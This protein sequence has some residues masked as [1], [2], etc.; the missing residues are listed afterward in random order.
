MLLWAEEGDGHAT[1]SVSLHDHQ[2][3]LCLHAGLNSETRSGTHPW[4][5]SSLSWS[6]VCT[7]LTSIVCRSSTF[8]HNPTRTKPQQLTGT[9]ILSRL[10]YFCFVAGALSPNSLPNPAFAGFE[11]LFGWT[12][13]VLSGLCWGV[14]LACSFGDELDFFPAEGRSASV[15]D[16]LVFGL[17]TGGGDLVKKLKRELCFAICP[18]FGD[19]LG[20]VC[21]ISVEHDPSSFSI[22]Q[23]PAR[24]RARAQ[25]S[26]ET[27]AWSMSADTSLSQWETRT[28]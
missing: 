22:T 23:R 4:T 18:T 17:D 2:L 24:Q 20:Y 27:Q 19:V 7:H 28:L 25:C 13:P 16:G 5:R 9:R 26:R 15:G 14:C 1:R 10:T 21:E 11:L 6:S 12:P 3:S 8:K